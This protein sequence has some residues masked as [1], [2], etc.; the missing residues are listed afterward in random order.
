MSA[1]LPFGDYVRANWGRWLIDCSSRYCT[2]AMQV[3]PGQ[4][5]VTCL[6]CGTTMGPLIWPADP[7]GVEALLSMRP[8]EKTR[9]WLPGETLQDLLMENV[10]HGI[11]PP[12][13]DLGASRPVELL[14]TVDERIVGGVVALSLTSDFRRH[15]IEE[16][17]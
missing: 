17:R 3:Y 14:T 1:L 10:A 13:L 5:L 16:G 12:G 4:V 15:Q 11:L 7:A 6:D 8:D 9:N 2:S